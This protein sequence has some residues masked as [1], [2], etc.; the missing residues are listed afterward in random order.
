MLSHHASSSQMKTFPSVLV[1]TTSAAALLAAGFGLYFSVHMAVAD[2]AYSQ[3]TPESLQKALRLEPGNA[4]FHA[5]YAEHE[6]GYGRTPQ[7]QLA[8]AISLSP[9]TSRYI[10][11]SALRA[12][13]DGDFHTA[14]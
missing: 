9:L 11:R 3:D 8:Q 14:E 2:Y 13:V 5:L 1:T 7:P 4:D 12:E 6:E 10:L